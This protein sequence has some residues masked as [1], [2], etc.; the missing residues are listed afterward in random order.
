[1]ARVVSIGNA[2]FESIVS[3]G[4]FYVD[5]TDFIKEWWDNRDIVTLITRPRRFGKTLT[6]NMIERFFSVKY[7]GQGALF[8]GL[9]IWKHEQFQ[10][11]QGT[12]PVISLSFAGIKYNTYEETMN[13]MKQIIARLYRSHAAIRNSG[14]LQESEVECFDRISRC[15]HGEGF[16]NSL[17]DL[18]DY[19]QR[20]YDKKVIVLL[21]EFDTP[22]QAAYIHGYWEELA[23]FMK[24]FFEATF[25]VNPFMGRSLLTGITRVSKESIFSGMNN[26]E[27]V[28]MTS[29]MYA[30]SFGFTQEEVSAALREFGLENREEEV[31]FWYDGFTIGSRTNIYNPWSIMNFLKGKK[32]QCYWANTSDNALVSELIRRGDSELK[33]EMERLLEGEAI[34]TKIDDQVAFQLLTSNFAQTSNVY[35]W[36]LLFASGYLKIVANAGR[37]QYNLKITNEEVRLMFQDMIA[38]WFGLASKYNDFI[39]SLLTGD[40]ELMNIYMNKVAESVFS[41]FDVGDKPSEKAEPERFYHGFVLGLMVDLEDRYVIASNRESGYGRYDVMLKPKKD[42]G[43]P[44]IVL[45]FKVHDPKDGRNL[46]S[47]VLAALQQIKDKKYVTTLVTEGFPEEKIRAYSFAFKGKTVLIDGG[48]L[49]KV[50]TIISAAKKKAQSVKSKAAGKKISIK[51]L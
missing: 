8:N 22:L 13:Q 51:N 34:L 42:K 11:L 2:D 4:S 12:I 21:D 28:S 40:V 7:A 31:R 39:K 17:R 20:F 33:V 35:V 6:M 30:D 45:E 43:L 23:S 9:D 44:S 41:T 16:V 37:D 48:D 32:F 18:S 24:M 15:Q 26:L 47:T 3:E 25:N 27:V 50:D 5:K 10:K 49:Q 14:I 46:G 1:M 38:K 36:S 19:M 29:D